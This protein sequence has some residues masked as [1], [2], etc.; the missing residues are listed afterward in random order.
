MVQDQCEGERTA[1]TFRFSPDDRLNQV[2][3][4]FKQ[5]VENSQP[6][7]PLYK[8]IRASLVKRFGEPTSTNESPAPDSPSQA[9]EWTGPTGRAALLFEQDSSSVQ[10]TVESIR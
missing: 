6:D 7:Y 8:K 1:V 2:I 3:C 5:G 9:V 4:K 10:L